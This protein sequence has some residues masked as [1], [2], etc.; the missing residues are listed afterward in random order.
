[1]GRDIQYFQKGG[2][3]LYGGTWHFIGGLDNPLETLIYHLTLI[4]L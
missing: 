4:S 3:T 1:M 2:R